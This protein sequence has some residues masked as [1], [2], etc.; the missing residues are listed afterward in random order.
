[1]EPCE[2]AFR[3]CLSHSQ[4][5]LLTNLSWKWMKKESNQRRKK[6]KS[7]KIE[8][9]NQ[10]QKKKIFGCETIAHVQKLK[11]NCK[12][13][14]Q[15]MKQSYFYLIPFNY[16]SVSIYCGSI[17]NSTLLCLLARGRERENDSEYWL[18]PPNW[19]YIMNVKKHTC[20]PSTRFELWNNISN[21][22]P[23]RRDVKNQKI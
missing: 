8:K 7:I 17:A 6:N 22:K 5:K 10:R 18:R 11:R 15:E 14:L 19:T 3:C 2:C 23:A 21:F 13:K 20:T 1:M 16:L 9:Q 12:R 4:R